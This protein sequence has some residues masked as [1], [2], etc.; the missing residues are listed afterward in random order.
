MIEAREAAKAGRRFHAFY[1]GV[2]A[3]RSGRGANPF[4]PGTE[5]FACWENGWKFFTAGQE[6]ADGPARC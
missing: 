6:D 5:E 1:Q 4:S 3:G 2:K